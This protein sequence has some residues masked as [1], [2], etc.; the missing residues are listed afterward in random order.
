M[1]RAQ[2]PSRF[3]GPASVRRILGTVAICISLVGSSPLLGCG[4]GAFATD[5]DGGYTQPGADAALEPASP[6]GLP[7]AWGAVTARCSLRHHYDGLTTYTAVFFRGELGKASM[8]VEWQ[9]LRN[10]QYNNPSRTESFIL[11]CSVV[12]LDVP[13]PLPDVDGPV[14]NCNEGGPE[15]EFGEAEAQ[16]WKNPLG[17]VSVN[18]H[19]SVGPGGFNATGKCDLE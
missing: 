13:F 4:G 19:A 5:E 2:L 8:D 16:L 18:A 17:E 10:G 7:G 6:G 12:E 15:L 9:D 1:T 11:S 3:R 14:V